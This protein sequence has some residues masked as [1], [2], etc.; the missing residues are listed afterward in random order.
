MASDRVFIRHGAYHY[1]LGRD[2]FG[3]RRSKV[4]CRVADGEHAMYEALGALLRPSAATIADLLRTF[5]AKGMGELA[6]RT[7]LD[8]VGYG[9]KLIKHF[10]SMVPSALRPSHVAKYLQNRSD[11]HDPTKRAPRIANKEIACLS[12][13]FEYGQR[14]ELCDGN[15]CRQVRRNRVRPKRRYARHDE[16]LEHFNL[17]SEEVQDL[18]AGIYLMELRPH[19]ARDLKRAAAITP[20]GVLLE[21]SKTDKMRLIQWS[22]PKNGGALQY[23]VLRATSRATD[24]PYVFTNSDGD[25]WTVDAMQ[26]AMKRLRDRVI[27]ARKEAAK[28]AGTE[29]APLATFTWHDVRAKGESDHQGGGMGLLP[30]YKRAHVVKPVW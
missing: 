18:M 5:F 21:E 27:A 19:E 10:G 24:S 9:P 8:Y 7:Q 4:L 16:F 28:E 11:A 1:D 23:F 13:A 30:L 6:P 14:A 2:E 26:S 15:P 22:D 3:K 20:K 29:R 12:S 25:K 17:A